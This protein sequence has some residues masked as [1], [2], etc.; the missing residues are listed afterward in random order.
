MR[1]RAVVLL[2]AASTVMAGAVALPSVAAS[3]SAGTSGASA[4][5]ARPATYGVIAERD[6]RVVM[7]DG[8]RLDVDV[9]R[10]AGQDGNAAP[11]R[12]P[13][14]VTF[15]P[16]NKNAP[17]LN[18]QND[19]LVQR[20][21]VQVIADIRGTGGSEGAWD[22]FGPLEQ[23][24]GKTLVEWAGAQPWSTGNVGM[25]GASYGG[26]IQLFTAAK[27]PKGLKA[28]FPI[29]PSADVYRDI[30][31]SGGQVNTSFIPFWLGLVTGTSSIPP[32][33]VTSD[34]AGAALTVANHAT[35]AS[36]FQAHTVAQ[37]LAG[38]TTAFDGPFY[39]T[40]ST[41][42]VIKQVKV[43]VFIVGGFYDLF[44]RGEQLLY[45]TL[46]NQG[47]P[48][49][50]VMG[51]WTHLQASEGQG[52]PKDGVPALSEQ[53]LRWFDRYVRDIP[54]AA[55]D[56]DVPQVRYVDLSTGHYKSASA[57]PPVGTTFTSYKL[58]G[59]SSLGGTSGTLSKATGTGSDTFPYIPVSGACT[60]S[61][62]QWSAGLAA[63]APCESDQSLNDSLGVS[64]DLPVSKAMKITGAVAAHLFVSTTG[65]DGQITARL[66][67]VDAA[68][69]ATQLTA[70]WQVL[71]LRKTDMTKSVKANGHVIQPW[72]PFTKSSV[73]PVKANEVYEVWVE[74][75]GTA[76]TIAPGHKLRLSLQAADS[77]HLTPP[78]PQLA[79]MLG[80]TL[81]VVHDAAHPSELIV[82]VGK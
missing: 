29:V 33:Y 36:G 19:Y 9:I 11:G 48:T 13:T 65:K 34:P 21:Y 35:N 56:R 22:S 67:D 25:F 38:D 76:T 41:I 77:P 44:Q 1:R 3:P 58:G 75:F 79:S 61:T 80:S 81:T 70:G 23:Q 31:G 39:R 14:I 15:T 78:V 28:I 42:E 12:F 71:S 24:D 59:V 69:K 6:K 27:Q 68:G 54:D 51:P 66:E 32:T 18:F 37:A 7:D 60:R 17:R 63:I 5:K 57:W 16:Y 40:R 64:Y 62:D 8:V 4:W 73:L 55:M 49:R 47:N 53:E 43:P 10:P 72:H 2:A 45:Q 82:P 26:I 46:R 52:L 50:L 20:G 74:I 30:V